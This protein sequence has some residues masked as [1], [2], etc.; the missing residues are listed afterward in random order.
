MIYVLNYTTYSNDYQFMQRGTTISSPTT[1]SKTPGSPA[2]TSDPPSKRQRVSLGGSRP[3][4]SDQQ[5][6]QAAMA[7]EQAKKDA[8]LER[9]ALEVGETRWVLSVRPTHI[10]TSPEIVVT[11]AGFAEIDEDD[12][13]DSE[14]EEERVGRLV[15]GKKVAVKSEDE[16]GSTDSEDD[17][18]EEEYDPLSVT[19][20]IARSKP[21][22]STPKSRGNGN[23]WKPKTISSGGGT[24]SNSRKRQ[25]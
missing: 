20:T 19:D 1:P 10:P 21:P 4:Y 25:P 16:S 8:A 15:F 14:E 17:S 22:V 24:P 12:D 23:P 13:E 18:E 3:R 11:N 5:A 2:S 7:E 6:I 9:H